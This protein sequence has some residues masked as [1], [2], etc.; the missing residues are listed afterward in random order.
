MALVVGASDEDSVA[1]DEG[2]DPTGPFDM[3]DGAR[4]KELP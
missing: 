3:E 2:G 1:L 4:T